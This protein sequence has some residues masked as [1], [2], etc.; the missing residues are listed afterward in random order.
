[1]GSNQG[2]ERG[3]NGVLIREQIENH[4]GAITDTEFVEALEMATLDIKS[5]HI[6]WGENTSLQEAILIAA[7]CVHT[8]RR[9]KK[10]SPEGPQLNSTFPL[11][12]RE[13]QNAT[14]TKCAIR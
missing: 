14:V 5:N 8:L 7:R 13:Y 4:I 3:A 2:T 9:A 12:R 6:M 11:Y 1:M 10:S